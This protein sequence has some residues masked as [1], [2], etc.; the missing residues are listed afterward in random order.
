M[1]AQTIIEQKPAAGIRRAAPGPR[2]LPLLG[3]LAQMRREGPLRFYA[4]AW[5]RYG[6]VTRLRLGPKVVQLFARPEHIRHI[7]V[8]NPNNYQKGVG[9][10]KLKLLLGNGLLTSEGA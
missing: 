7:L 4:Q 3:N 8:Q 6:D 5:R 2:G 9:Y 1:M 10:S